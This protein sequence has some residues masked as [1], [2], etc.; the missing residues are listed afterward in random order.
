ME[1]GV[2]EFCAVEF[3]VWN[4]VLVEFGGSTVEYS[5]VHECSA[6]DFEFI[7]HTGSAYGLL[8]PILKSISKFNGNQFA[9]NCLQSIVGNQFV[10]WVMI[11]NF[12]ANK[13][14]NVG[15]LLV[16]LCKGGENSESER[17][18]GC[19]FVLLA[20]AAPRLKTR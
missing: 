20:V 12:C 18:N 3:G 4:F 6:L 5:I 2:V 9:I 8:Y 7:I 19:C 16:L 17:H 1:F 13:C 15:E 14:A 11:L 10:S